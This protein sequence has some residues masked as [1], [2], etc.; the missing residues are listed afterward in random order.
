MAAA[1]DSRSEPGIARLYERGDAGEGSKIVDKM[2]LV[3]VSAIGRELG[4]VHGHTLLDLIQQS[5]EPPN[6]AK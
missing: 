2:R 5:P 4:P 3:E 6:T 1:R